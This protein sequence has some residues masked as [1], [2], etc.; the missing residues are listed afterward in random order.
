MH[1]RADVQRVI[2]VQYVYRRLLCWRGPFQGALL[3]EVFDGSGETPFPLIESAV[4]LR[5]PAAGADGRREFRGRLS[6]RDEGDDECDGKQ[7]R[8]EE[9]TRRTRKS[10]H[11]GIEGK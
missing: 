9:V 6:V 4:Y 1:A 5:Y 2:V 3:A 8:Q 10:R 7:Q 11:G